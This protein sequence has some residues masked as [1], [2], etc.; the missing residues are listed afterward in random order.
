MKLGKINRILSYVNLVLVVEVW[1]G[2][3]EWEP[4]KL[5]LQSKRRYDARWGKEPC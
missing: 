3:G 4:T 2:K 1:D 5:W